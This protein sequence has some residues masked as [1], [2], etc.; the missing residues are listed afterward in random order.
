MAKKSKMNESSLSQKKEN[1]WNNLPIACAYIYMC[2][3]TI[4]VYNSLAC[5]STGYLAILMQQSF[6]SFTSLRWTQKTQN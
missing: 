3:Y 6:S 5:Q 2:V 1:N 4:C